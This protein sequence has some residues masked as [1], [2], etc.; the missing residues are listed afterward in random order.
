M[1]KLSREQ[2]QQISEVTLENYSGRAQ[3]FWEGTR[4]HDVSQNVEALLGAIEGEGPYRILDFGC[5]N[6]G[7]ILRGK[8]LA[9]VKVGLEVEVLS[10]EVLKN[11]SLSVV[12]DIKEILLN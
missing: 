7:F 12:Q 5:G 2:L 9:A 8:E 6:G 3:D 1:S 4:D 10:R 11:E